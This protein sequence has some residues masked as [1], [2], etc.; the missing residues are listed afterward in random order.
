MG[1]PRVMYRT[2]LNGGLADAFATMQNRFLGP[3]VVGILG[4][5]QIDC[6]GNLNSTVIG[7]YQSLKCAFPAAAAPATW[8][9]SRGARSCSCSTSAE[10]SWK[11][12]TTSPP[13]AGW[14]APG[15]GAGG[16]VAGGPSAVITNMAVMRFDETTRRMYLDGCYPESAGADTQENTGFAVPGHTPPVPTRTPPSTEELR[17][18]REKCDPQRLIPGVK[19]RRIGES[20]GRGP[21]R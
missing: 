17:I 5:A 6:Y 19:G 16:L 12:W 7:D 18:L 14:T 9:P 4:A 2:A 10:N 11:P 15:P 1:D 13:P 8:H 21:G 20:V 3:R